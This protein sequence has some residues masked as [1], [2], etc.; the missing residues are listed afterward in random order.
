LSGIKDGSV[1]SDFAVMMAKNKADETL[2]AFAGNLS[3]VTTEADL[4][5]KKPPL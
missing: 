5:T 1:P 4:L 2:V 3:Y